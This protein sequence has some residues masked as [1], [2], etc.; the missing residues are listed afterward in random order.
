MPKVS[1]TAPPVVGQLADEY[2]DNLDAVARAHERLHL[3]L[4]NEIF[5]AAAD[6]D[7]RD[8]FRDFHCLC[9]SI[10]ERAP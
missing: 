3:H 8:D 6:G 10:Q 1:V 9:A 7:V 2:D 5:V 4:T